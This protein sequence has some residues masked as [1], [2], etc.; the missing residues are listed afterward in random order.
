MKITNIDADRGKVSIKWINSVNWSYGVL[1]VRELVLAVQQ[2]LAKPCRVVPG[3]ER[4]LHALDH[5]AQVVQGL[6]DPCI[7]VREGRLRV[8][9]DLGKQG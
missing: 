8:L 3:S 6:K 5:T 2:V 4:F 7:L 9:V 1:T